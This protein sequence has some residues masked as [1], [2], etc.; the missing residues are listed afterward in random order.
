MT[1]DFSE[2]D[3]N[4]PYF[5][6]ENN[7]VNDNVAT[8]TLVELEQRITALEASQQKI[9]QV[10]KSIDECLAR[11]VR[12]ISDTEDAINAITDQINQMIN[13][14]NIS[15]LN[16]RNDTAAINQNAFSSHLELSSRLLKVEI[17]LTEAK[18]ALGEFIKATAQ[19]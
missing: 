8:A 3:N 10:N 19:F 1:A 7:N 14:N 13:D 4:D 5:D 18:E 12:R 17:E 11:L 15:L 6:W 9:E 16:M 2:F